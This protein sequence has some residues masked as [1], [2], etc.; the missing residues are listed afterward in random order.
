MGCENQ[1]ASGLQPIAKVIEK[2]G[3]QV[4][5]K[6]RQQRPYPDE[7]VI[8]AFDGNLTG[9]FIGIDRLCSECFGT[10]VDTVG[11]LIASGDL[12]G[13]ELRVHM[14]EYPPVTTRQIENALNLGVWFVGCFESQ[15]DP[16]ECGA[17][18]LEVRILAS[19][20]REHFLGGG[21][22]ANEIVVG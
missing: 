1:H 14:S 4:L 9:V 13:R 2:R 16:V 12:C 7:V 3:P 19:I 10:V 20:G 15:Q 8:V 11:Q 17:T 5:I 18:N 21:D 6:M 22:L